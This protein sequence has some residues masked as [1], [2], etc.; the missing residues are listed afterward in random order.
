MTI[1]MDFDSHEMR[2][3]FAPEIGREYVVVE[4]RDTIS[5][6]TTYQFKE[7]ITGVSGNMDSSVKRFHGWR[8]TTNNTEKNALGVRRVEDIVT[9]KNGMSKVTLSA[10]LHPDWE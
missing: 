6:A 10:D 7:E 3:G 9:Y 2:Y 4:Y 8:G 1:R 5:G